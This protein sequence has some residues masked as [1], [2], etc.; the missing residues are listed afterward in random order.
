MGAEAHS[1]SIPGGAASCDGAMGACSAGRDA[2][3]C[4]EV[5]IDGQCIRAGQGARQKQAE[6][7]P[8]QSQ[9]TDNRSE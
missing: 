6:K 1:E 5:R 9:L 2:I 3:L 8:R 4:A 7:W